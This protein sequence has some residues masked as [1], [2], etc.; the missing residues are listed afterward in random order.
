VRWF[1]SVPQH[2]GDRFGKLTRVWRK[3]SLSYF[4][5][6]VLRV[7]KQVETR[8]S[9]IEAGRQI[10]ENQ[11]PLERHGNGLQTNLDLFTFVEDFFI[12]VDEGFL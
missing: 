12:P 9:P 7:H 4:R 2:Y 10:Y 5:A 8:V 3:G 1:F 11:H 6:Q